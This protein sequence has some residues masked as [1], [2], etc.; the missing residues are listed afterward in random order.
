MRLR[1]TLG[2]IFC[3][4]ISLNLTGC[5]GLIGGAMKAL[6][7]DYVKVNIIPN[8]ETWNT[9]ETGAKSLG[10]TASRGSDNGWALT[11]LSEK[12]QKMEMMKNENICRVSS[13]QSYG[14]GCTGL[15]F[16]CEESASQHEC[17]ERFIKL[18]KAAGMD[19]EKLTFGPRMEATDKGKPYSP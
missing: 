14:N 13:E 16:V 2:L 19:S 10:W 11:V 7:R 4:S 6:N 3:V 8:A 5:F 12:K 18:A 15:T 9:L 1:T 17:I